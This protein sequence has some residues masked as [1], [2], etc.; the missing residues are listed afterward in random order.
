M[1]VCTYIYTYIY[2]IYIYIYIYVHTNTHACNV[3]SMYVVYS[4]DTFTCAES[5]RVITNLQHRSRNTAQDALLTLNEREFARLS[6]A[7]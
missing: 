2:I 4:L 1:Q 5:M 3:D 7:I 6:K